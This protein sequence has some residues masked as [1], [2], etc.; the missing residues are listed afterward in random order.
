MNV[1]IEICRQFVVSVTFQHENLSRNNPKFVLNISEFSF[2]FLSLS[3]SLKMKPFQLLNL[4]KNS[5]K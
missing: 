5:F 2:P 1:K 4:L 3:L